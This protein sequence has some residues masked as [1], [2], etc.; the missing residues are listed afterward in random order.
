[1][2]LSPIR[3]LLWDVN[4]SDFEGKAR[5]Y[6]EFLAVRVA[7]KGNESDLNWYF[8]HFGFKRFIDVIF[9]NREVSSQTRNFWR[10]FLEYRGQ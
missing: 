1:M 6:D 8:K 7:E 9:S 4:L 5:E 2:P 3:H 10:L